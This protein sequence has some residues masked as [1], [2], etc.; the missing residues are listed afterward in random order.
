MLLECL[1]L[2]SDFLQL[3]SSSF[4]LGFDSTVICST[5]SGDA[6]ANFNKLAQILEI[7]QGQQQKQHM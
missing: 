5:N 1:V 3:F 4:L 2:S 6:K 7:I